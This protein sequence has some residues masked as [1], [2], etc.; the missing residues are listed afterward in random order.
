MLA[1]GVRRSAGQRRRRPCLEPSGA[2]RSASG[3]S[4]SRSSCTRRSAARPSGSTSSTAATGARI[5]QKRVSAPTAKRSTYDEIVKGY[6]LP[7][8]EY[9]TV[10]DEELAGAR[11]RGGPHDRH[12]RVRRP[13]RH[14]S[15]LLR[16]R[17]LPGARRGDRQA[18]RAAGARRWRRRTRSAWPASSCG[19]SSTWPPCGPRT[20]ASCCRRWCTPTR[21]TPSDEIDGFDRLD[22]IEMTDAELAM[23]DQLIDSLAAEFEPG[24]FQ[25][26]PPRRGARADRA[27]GRR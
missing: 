21:S 7:T 14:R 4:T 16:L 8:G 17:L 18:L 27:Q 22:D 2:G 10:T 5:K 25:R 26:H 6:E 23:A 3:W 11:S 9:V 20:G 1:D 15:D 12:R 13:R 24:R 19:P